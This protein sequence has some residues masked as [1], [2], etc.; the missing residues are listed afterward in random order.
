MKYSDL[1]CYHVLDTT[2]DSR[3]WLWDL[4]VKLQIYSAKSIQ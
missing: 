1:D 4:G 2:V 3:I